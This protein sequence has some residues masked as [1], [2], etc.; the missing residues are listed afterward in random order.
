MTD[1][2]LV[3]TFKS[4]ETTWTQGTLSD[5]DWGKVTRGEV[6]DPSTL[7]G[8]GVAED[9]EDAAAAHRGLGGLLGGR[10]A[11]GTRGAGGAGSTG[12]GG[13]GRGRR[14]A[15]EEPA[16]PTGNPGIAQPPQRTDASAPP[17]AT[18]GDG[19]PITDGEGAPP[20]D[21]ELSDVATTRVADLAQSTP[22]KVQAGE[23]RATKADRGLK[24]QVLEEAMADYAADGGNP[25]D[26]SA[27]QLLEGHGSE[28]PITLDDGTQYTVERTD[29]VFGN[30]YTLVKVPTSSA[31]S[32]AG[33]SDSR[34]TGSYLPAQATPGYYYQHGASI[35]AW[36]GQESTKP[37]GSAEQL[38]M[39]R[40]ND[41]ASKAGLSPDQAATLYYLASNTDGNSLPYLNGA[42]TEYTAFQGRGRDTTIKDPFTELRVPT[43]IAGIT[44][45]DPRVNIRADDAGAQLYKMKLIQEEV[46]GDDLTEAMTDF[47]DQARDA[48]SEGH[49]GM[50]DARL[51]VFNAMATDANEDSQSGGSSGGD[52][53]SSRSGEL[54]VPKWVDQADRRVFEGYLGA[55]GELEE[56]D[57]RRLKA[58]EAISQATSGNKAS[59]RRAYAAVDRALTGQNVPMPD[60]LGE[61]SGLSKVEGAAERGQ[62]W[63]GYVDAGR[64]AVDGWMKFAGGL[65]DTALSKVDEHMKAAIAT[66]KEY[67]DYSRGRTAE[68]IPKFVER[69]ENYAKHEAPNYIEG[70]STGTNYQEEETSE[71]EGADQAGATDAQAQLNWEQAMAEQIRRKRSSTK[72]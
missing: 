69:D 9:S 45:R 3:T 72:A 40:V 28:N 26:V 12:T 21:T 68:S 11:G 58:E 42:G 29:G 59:Q 17:G 62:K 46:T 57:P 31:T 27:D 36:D 38:T 10:G 49:I 64:G 63:L 33:D 37:A 47:D 18:G 70:Y 32:S 52:G 5:D 16:A 23:G 34:S 43:N 39:A 44:S 50:P 4:G 22:L 67:V 20:E 8:I 56:S 53:T 61:A 7:S 13:T 65:R 24:Q 6:T 55:L 1:P 51:A 66:T 35:P 19:P 54:K 2:A 14:G 60:D 41:L 48:M 25:A 71:V 30:T 15:S